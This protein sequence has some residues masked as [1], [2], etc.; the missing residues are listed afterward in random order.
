MTAAIEL[1]G[2]TKRFGAVQAL[3][4]IDLTVEP[5]EIV[6]LLGPSGSGKTT[7]LRLVG[8]LDEPTAGHVTVDGG[9]PHDARAGKRIGFVPQSPAL[10]PWRTVAANA[11]LLLDVNRRGTHGPRAVAD[12]AARRRRPRSTSPTPTRTSCRA[13]CSSASRWCGRWPSARRCC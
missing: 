9:S 1:V 13:A 7:L 8:G 6:T 10:L 2:V 12:R 4:A 11:R 5:G 3:D